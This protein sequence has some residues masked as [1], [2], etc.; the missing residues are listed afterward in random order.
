MTQGLYCQLYTLRLF[1]LFLVWPQ[2]GLHPFFHKLLHLLRR[3]PDKRL[4]IQQVVQ[5]PPYRLEVCVISNPLDEVVLAA[6]LLDHPRGLV[7]EDPDT[8]VR[9]LAVTDGAGVG[10]GGCLR[11]ERHDDILSCHEG[12]LLRDARG[13]DLWVHD[14]AFAY[15]LKGAQHDVCGEERL[16]KGDPA[17]CTGTTARGRMSE[18]DD[19]NRV[20]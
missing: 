18:D 9:F 6:L 7:G 4:G 3:T 2:S 5:D 19:Q 14:E 1:N 11:D 12:Q 8:F 20:M 15:I 16:G 13:N 17:V 10:T